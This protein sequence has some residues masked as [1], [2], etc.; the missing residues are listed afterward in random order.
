MESVEERVDRESLARDSVGG[1]VG[2]ECR[3]GACRG[4]VGGE[5]IRYRYSQILY[6]HIRK[7]RL[8][9]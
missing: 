2:G 3:E 1:D 8:C 7:M 4:D 5:C 6:W 9:T